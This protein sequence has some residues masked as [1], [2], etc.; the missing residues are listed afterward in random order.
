MNEKKT[1]NHKK[2]LKLFDNTEW[3]ANEK[4]EKREKMSRAGENKSAKA[5]ITM[6]KSFEMRQL[7]E[8]NSEHYW[9]V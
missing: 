5:F 8:M 7:N 1:S 4:N 2:W 9:N 3:E 6:N